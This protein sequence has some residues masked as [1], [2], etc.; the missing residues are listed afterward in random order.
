VLGE[1]QGERQPPRLG[2]RSAAE[3][4]EREAEQRAVRDVDHEPHTRPASGEPA[5]ESRVRVVD[6][7][8]ASVERLR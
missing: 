2:S 4:L 3:L 8:D 1:R 7:E 6:A 5:E